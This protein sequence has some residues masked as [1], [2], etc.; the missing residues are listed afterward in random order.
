MSIQVAAPKIS[1]TSR[2]NIAV[3]GLNRIGQRVYNRIGE[4]LKAREKLL[5][6]IDVYDRGMDEINKWNGVR[7]LGSL[8]NFSDL[9]LKN[10]INY[11]IIAVDTSDLSLIHKIVRFCTI[12]RIPFEFAPEI[13]DEIY[14]STI[15]EIFTDLKRPWQP[16]FR[17]IVDSLCAA[18]LLTFFMPLWIIVGIMIKL[19]SEGPIIFSQERIGIGGRI[20]RV[21]KFRT[22]Y[23]DAEKLSGP[24]LATKND[25]RI[26]KVGNI[27]RKTRIDEIPQ[28]INVMIGDMSFIGPRPERPYFVD[29]YSYE[30]PMYINR[31]K[32][33]PGITG[34]AQITTGYDEDLEDVK[35]KLYYDLQY[36]EK[37]NS[38]R[39]NLS[40][41]FKTF[42]V[43]VTGQ[44]Q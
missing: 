30:I 23:V 18:I 27:L 32:I 19:T 22:M 14:G 42:T 24:V 1:K 12:A 36:V 15:H 44:G 38:W 3:I 34:L 10:K 6:V 35:N 25:P 41:I 43:V 7:F 5:G 20:F 40:I 4:Q 31:L 8:K 16:S 9:I 33:K 17:Q 2:R 13:K 29:K 39:M 26:T 37:F 21:F 28:L 11:V